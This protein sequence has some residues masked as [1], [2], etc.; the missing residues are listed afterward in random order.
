[1]PLVVVLPTAA[2][3]HCSLLEVTY[4]NPSHIHEPAV[5]PLYSSCPPYP[6]LHYA[7]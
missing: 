6:A 3:M 2:V 4:T 7:S 1:M 5:R